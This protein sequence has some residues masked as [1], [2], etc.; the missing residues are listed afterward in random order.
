MSPPGRERV[1][2]QGTR[3]RPSGNRAS[4]L[5]YA[6][7]VFGSGRGLVHRDLKPANLFPSGSG[8]ARVAKVGDYGLSKAFDEAGLSGS[9][10]TGEAAGTPHFMAR[11]QVIDFK[12]SAPEVDVWAMAASLYNMLTGAV[13]RDFP[14]REDP[15]LVVLEKPPVPIRQRKPTLRKELAQVIDK[16][17][18]EEPAIGFPTA[19]AFKEALEDVA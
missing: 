12:C 5:H 17:L 10:R 19:A 13:P 11:Q 14:P 3:W 6:H 16:A 1:A 9:T 8:S 4:G 7:N 18:V 15:W 2:E